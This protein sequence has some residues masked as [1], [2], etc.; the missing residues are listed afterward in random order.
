MPVGHL[1]IHFWSLSPTSNKMI[2]LSLSCAH[3]N[4]HKKK[5][6]NPLESIPWDQ[7][8]DKMACI[9][10][11]LD[12]SPLDSGLCSECT[13]QR[14]QFLFSFTL[15]SKGDSDCCLT[16]SAWNR[17]QMT[18]VFLSFILYI[19]IIMR[20]HQLFESCNSPRGAQYRSLC[21]Y[22]DKCVS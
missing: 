6:K 19:R 8:L 15:S 17:S 10:H 13:L 20:P 12:N 3:A 22:G 9:I 21:V 2:N 11:S 16:V 7:T 1:S 14:V 4:S 5:K 18:Q